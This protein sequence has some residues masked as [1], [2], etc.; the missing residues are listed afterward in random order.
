MASSLTR[1][2]QPI[3]LRTEYIASSPTTIRVK[4][5]SNS[6]SA[7]DFTVSTVANNDSGTPPQTLFTVDGDFASVSQR[8]RMQD[9]TGLPLFE[10]A[11]K[12]LGVTW[13]VHLPGSKERDEPQPIATIVPQFHM[14]KD[15][16][17]VY[18]SNAAAAGGG[19]DIVL[20]VRG[21]DIWKYKTHVYYGDALVM[22]A[23]LTDMV[24]VYIPGKRPE[25]EIEVAEGMDLSLASIIGV[26]LA[27]MLYQ[28]AVK[29]KA[30]KSVDEDGDPACIWSPPSRSG[31]PARTSVAG[32]LVRP[33]SRR[34]NEGEKRRKRSLNAL[35][36]T[37][38]EDGCPESARDRPQPT[39]PAV[40]PLRIPSLP[41][42]VADWNISDI[43]SF[44]TPRSSS[45]ENTFPSLWTQIPTGPGSLGN[46]TSTPT[47]PSPQRLDSLQDIT[48]ELSSIN[49]S[50]FDLE[51][52]LHAEPWG[53]MFASPAAVISKLSTCADQP[54]D[55]LA[56]YP[57]I[58][59][60]NKTQHFINIARQTR[61]YFA[62]LPPP[63]PHA[64]TSTSSS[65]SRPTST[66]Q[67]AFYPDSDTSSQMSS[68]LS[69]VDMY[70]HQ[71]PPPHSASSTTQGDRPGGASCDL[72]TAL[73]YTTGYARILNLYTTISTQMA[74][75][76]HALSVQS[77]TGGPDYRQRMHPVI[78][79]LQWGGFQPANYSALQI[80]MA[81]QV[82]SYLLTQVERA[83]DVDEWEDEVTGQRAGPATGRGLLSPAMIEIVVQG[84]G[85]GDRG[86]KVGLL[87]RELK[88]LK[89]ELEMSMHS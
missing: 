61:V 5:H 79:P 49:L 41:P 45:Q 8:R 81:I 16:F 25:W 32:K 33:G 62:S 58:D 7:G 29:G 3:A 60:F 83:L 77:I 56:Q 1:L 76:V 67:A 50:L 4:Q 40:E 89:K 80:L 87:R 47:V 75:F 84:E 53:P 26:L 73:L 42:S 44:S 38:E 15:K 36:L 37:P 88:R 86:G 35:E 71:M 19:E 28:S 17:D 85:P 39:P 57:L 63:T 31:R 51:Q 82:M 70:I 78:P 27:A 14:L 20:S 6:W 11:R 66:S 54:D 68:R 24:S 43:F 21:Q 13:F 55:T 74:H 10:L 72:P 23:K 34:D 48:R 18:F 22:T 30:P 65:T 46:E 52:S 64:S 12:R 2:K 9:A 69:P 59:I